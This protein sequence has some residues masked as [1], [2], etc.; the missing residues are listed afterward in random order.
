[1]KTT[2]SSA[3]AGSS[4]RRCRCV[5]VGDAKYKRI[6]VKGTNHPDL[7]QL[8]AYTVALDLP[9]GLLVYAAGE[10]ERVE[11]VIV[12]A[13]KRL[14]VTTVDIRGAPAHILTDVDRIARRVEEMRAAEYVRTAV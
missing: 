4:P 1:V 10:A 14:E 7:Y 12:H 5:F 2:L 13:G 11:H 9:G 3:L 8:L 6:N